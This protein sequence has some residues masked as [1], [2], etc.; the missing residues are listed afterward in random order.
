[1]SEFNFNSEEIGI[2]QRLVA[3]EV[4][5]C[6]DNYSYLSDKINSA[7]YEDERWKCSEWEAL[8]RS[9]A[10]T[11]RQAK[12]ASDLWIYLTEGKRKENQ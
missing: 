12:V 5:R 6:K 3:D 8:V 7:K 9:S 2:L 10:E 11:G 1:M 4:S